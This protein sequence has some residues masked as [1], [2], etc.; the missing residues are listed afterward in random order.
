L[1]SISPKEAAAAYLCSCGGEKAAEDS[2]RESAFFQAF[3]LFSL[4]FVA[5][6]R[7][8]AGGKLTGPEAGNCF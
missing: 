2:S 3:L 1:A 8:S 5:G 7:Y 6:G 4:A